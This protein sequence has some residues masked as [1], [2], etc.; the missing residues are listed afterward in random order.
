[1]VAL[2]LQC[3][4]APLALSLSGRVGSLG[5]PSSQAS[6]SKKRRQPRP[7][8]HLAG[9]RCDEWAPTASP[10]IQLP[11]PANHNASLTHHFGCAYMCMLQAPEQLTAMLVLA[12]CAFLFPSDGL[13][14]QYGQAGRCAANCDCA[15]C[16]SGFNECLDLEPPNVDGCGTTDGR[17]STSRA[18]SPVPPPCRVIRRRVAQCSCNGQRTLR[19]TGVGHCCGRFLAPGH[20]S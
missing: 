13:A 7:A 19:S 15:C 8:P 11:R 14:R 16:V 12:R 10:C 3:R 17:C 18:E 9:E 6:A 4:T 2:P 5:I 20:A 1:M